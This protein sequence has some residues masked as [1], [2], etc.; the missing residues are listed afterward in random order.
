MTVFA[1]HV[2]LI[3]S[4]AASLLLSPVLHAQAQAARADEGDEEIVDFAAEEQDSAA[5]SAAIKAAALGHVAAA[6]TASAKE[7]SAEADSEEEVDFGLEE[8]AA[9]AES[10]AIQAQAGALVGDGKK[11]AQQDQNM[12]AAQLQQAKDLAYWRNQDYPELEFST[13]MAVGP[14]LV[15]FWMAFQVSWRK[16]K[17]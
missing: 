7:D 14:V 11:N 5:E 8:E 12:T 9:D 15:L 4:L 1:R 3:A 2:L 17:K 13:W 16:Q 10:A 6:D